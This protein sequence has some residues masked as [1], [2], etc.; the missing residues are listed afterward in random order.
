MRKILNICMAVVLSTSFGCND[1]NA[2]SL[3]HW[4]DPYIGTGGHGHTFLGVA[5]PFGTLQLG[6]TNINKGWNCSSLNQREISELPV[7]PC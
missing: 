1:Q 6:P 4:V 3:T 7:G 2:V 5:A